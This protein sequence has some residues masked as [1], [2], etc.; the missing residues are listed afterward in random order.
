MSVEPRILN[1]DFL[2]TLKNKEIVL[3][4]KSSKTKIPFVTL[5]PVE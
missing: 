3:T 1:D 2:I 5:K 4:G